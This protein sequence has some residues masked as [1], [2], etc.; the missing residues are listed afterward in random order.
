MLQR[1]RAV[2][3]LL[4]E[5]RALSPAGRG[6]V[7]SPATP[8]RAVAGGAHPFGPPPPPLTRR[9]QV[10]RRCQSLSDVNNDRSSTPPPGQRL[11][12]EGAQ[13][14]WKSQV[15]T[16]AEQIDDDIDKK[17]PAEQRQAFDMLEDSIF[18]MFSRDG[19]TIQ[20]GKFLAALRETGLRKNDRRLREMTENL[21]KV[22]EERSGAPD[23][24]SPE[25]QVLDLPTFRRLVTSN[26]HLISR[27]MRQRFV[28]PDFTNFCRDIE[29]IY[30]HCK[31]SAGGKEGE[32]ASYIPQLARYDPNFWGVSVCTVDGQRYC[33]GDVTVPFTVQSIS[34]PLTYGLVLDEL[35][36][37]MVHQYVG[38]EPSGR[39]FNELVLDHNKKHTT[40]DQ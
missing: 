6:A 23:V 30:W 3:R 5:Q 8:T 21:Y 19:K 9:L 31:S 12:S 36:E 20:I 2:L 4:R 40:H 25:S 14:S 7:S 24:H 16:D 15:F 39:M 33:I 10:T 17:S 13:G 22:Y 32:V 28:I 37:D 1:S 38:Q 27:A 29:A 35:G 11:S 18:Y 26:I 34:K